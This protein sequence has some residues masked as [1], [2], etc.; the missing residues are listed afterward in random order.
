MKEAAIRQV[1]IFLENAVKFGHIEK[2]KIPA[3]IATRSQQ[4]RSYISIRQA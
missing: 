4:P 3:R 1:G 2:T